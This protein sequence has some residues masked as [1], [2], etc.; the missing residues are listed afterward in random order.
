MEEAGGVVTDAYGEPLDFGLGKTLKAN[1]GL[2]A[3]PANVHAQV[4]KAVKEELGKP[5]L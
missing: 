5:N 2:I 1:K 4:I 3:T